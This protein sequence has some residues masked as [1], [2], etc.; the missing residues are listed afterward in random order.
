MGFLSSCPYPSISLSPFIMAKAMK[1]AVEEAPPMKKGMRRAMKA[2]KAVSVNAKAM[3]AMKA[4]KVVSVSAKAMKAMKAMK[5][6]SVNA[7]GHEGDEGH[8]G[9]ERE[10]EGHEGDEGH[11]VSWRGVIGAWAWLRRVVVSTSLLSVGQ[12]MHLN[13][14]DRGRTRVC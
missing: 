1:K 4:M 10:R 12:K 11:E 8:E 2:M 14:S 3:K 5:V 13:L 6:V 9:R 7:E